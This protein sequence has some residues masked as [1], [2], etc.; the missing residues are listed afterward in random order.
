LIARRPG[1]PE[2]V[3]AAVRFLASDAASYVTATTLF[4]DGGISGPI[5]IPQSDRATG[6]NANECHD[7]QCN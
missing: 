7:R 4:V 3:A 1:R 2:E 5:T 6:A